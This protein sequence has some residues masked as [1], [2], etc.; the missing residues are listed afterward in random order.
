LNS[1]HPD[2]CLAA[3]RAL[4]V[5]SE[6]D[7]PWILS[8]RAA[9][10][11]FRNVPQPIGQLDLVW[12]GI[13]FLGPLAQ[14]VLQTLAAAGL[15]AAALHHGSRR[16]S[17]GAQVGHSTCLLRLTAEAAPPLEAPLRTRLCGAFVRI[18][19]PREVLV[20]ALCSL[21]ERP[22]VQDLEDVGLL[23]RNGVS[24]EL[25]LRDASCRNPAFFPQQ[26][27][28]RLAHFD[29]QD[30]ELSEAAQLKLRRLQEKIVFEI[31]KWGVPDSRAS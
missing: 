22:D 5:L 30:P 1:Y 2:L 29:T 12:H 23:L 27:A 4:A 15:D 7:P 16:V 26:L 10:W 17:L 19:K 11:W 6:L 13:D 31:L 9:L 24:L 3:R 21:Y 25:G 8:G 28:Q 18:E 14:Q 20:T